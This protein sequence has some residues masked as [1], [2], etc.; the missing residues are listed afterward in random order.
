MTI[1][2][3]ISGIS[4]KLGK[5]ITEEIE[6]TDKISLT[7]GQ[8]SF[9]NKHLGKPL[10]SFLKTNCNAN[11]VSDFNDIQDALDVVIDVSSI[12]NFE[13]VTNFCLKNNLPLILASTGHSEDQL[14]LLERYS[15][16]LPILIAPNLS[17]GINL[18]KKSLLSLKGSKSINKIQITETHHKEKKDAPSGTAIDLAKFIDDYLDLDIHTEIASIRDDSSVGV[19]EIKICLDNDELVLTH[20]AF[21]RRIFAKGAI[22]AIEW[23]S[24]QKSGLYSM[25]EISF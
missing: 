20:N 14:L 19:H 9:D 18:L 4:G 12:D 3:L 10:S 6:N 13:N 1:S 15:L 5:V 25:Q 2:L 17:L 8:A 23:V 21:D 24:S 16:D 22:K 7:A 11:L